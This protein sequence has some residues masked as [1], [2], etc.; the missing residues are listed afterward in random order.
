MNLQNA[1]KYGLTQKKKITKYARFNL[2]FHSFVF[3]PQNIM[4]LLCIEKARIVNQ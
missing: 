3:S 1:I 4:A 2:F